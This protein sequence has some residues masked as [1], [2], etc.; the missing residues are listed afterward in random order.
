MNVKKIIFTLVAVILSCGALLLGLGLNQELDG[1]ANMMQTICDRGYN[2]LSRDECE[3]RFGTLDA[4]NEGV[5]LVE[6]LMCFG[7]SLV[8]LL[9]LLGF[10]ANGGICTERGSKVLRKGK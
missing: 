5:L 2:N 7:F 3:M 9:V 10:W 8:F 6:R 4:I 1:R